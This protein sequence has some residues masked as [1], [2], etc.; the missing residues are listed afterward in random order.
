[1]TRSVKCAVMDDKVAKTPRSKQSV[2]PL[3]IVNQRSLITTTIPCVLC[4]V[5]IEWSF[6]HASAL[7]LSLSLFRAQGAASN[8]RD[9]G[10]W[11]SL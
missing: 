11:R 5:S 6:S 8:R 10:P 1:M 4:A 2:Y 9:R 7:S 3:L